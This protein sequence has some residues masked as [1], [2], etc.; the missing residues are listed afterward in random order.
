MINPFLQRYPE[1]PVLAT[2]LV[3]GDNKKGV[4]PF[5]APSHR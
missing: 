1:Q 5:H 4:E 2:T 3:Y